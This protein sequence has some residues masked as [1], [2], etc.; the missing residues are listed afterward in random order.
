MEVAA[1]D[2]FLHKAEILVNRLNKSK[3]VS[4]A[5]GD[6]KLDADD[7]GKAPIPLDF[8]TNLSVIGDPFL[9]E[10]FQGTSFTHSLE[11]DNGEE[12]AHPDDSTDSASSAYYKHL[13]NE[14]HSVLVTR[15][16]SRISQAK[17]PSLS[18]NSAPNM[19][20][21]TPC[22]R[23]RTAA[24]EPSSIDL[25]VSNNNESTAEMIHPTPKPRSKYA[26]DRI[27]QMTYVSPA[28]MM[29]S[30]PLPMKTLA[31]VIAQR[32]QQLGCVEETFEDETIFEDA[33]DVTI[34]WL[35]WV[36]LLINS[37]LVKFWT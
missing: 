22:V 9:E 19:V 8:S 30:S 12:G 21:S 31:S 5:Q 33:E 34:S 11:W 37:S 2:S 26:S 4:S 28:T 6:Q 25:S 35:F 7:T 24:R 27:E 16:K 15:G 32:A 14:L 10:V 20:T 36:S 17:T 23:P 3:Q 29:D 1:A 13:M 18:E